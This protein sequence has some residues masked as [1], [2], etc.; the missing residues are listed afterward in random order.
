MDFDFGSRDDQ[1]TRSPILEF[2]SH[3][4]VGRRQRS[5]G[6]CYSHEDISISFTITFFFH[7]SNEMDPNSFLPK[8]DLRTSTMPLTSY[9]TIWASFKL[10]YQLL[11]L[12]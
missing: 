12:S 8:S 10:Y 1:V 5:S 6:G 11:R 9:A 4:F 3:A 7:L 2:L